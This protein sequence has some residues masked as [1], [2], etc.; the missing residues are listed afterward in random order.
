MTTTG[1]A[2]VIARKLEEA[3]APRHLEVL[4][5]SGNHNVRPGAQSHFRLVVVSERFQQQSRLSRHRLIY[6]LLG[7]EL[8][9]SVHALAIQAHTV[10]EWQ[11]Q[12]QKLQSSPPCRG[13]ESGQRN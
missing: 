10:E 8:A 1:T 13:G 3:L 11:R 2:G 4:D 9:G 7:E 5:E 6:E 12:D